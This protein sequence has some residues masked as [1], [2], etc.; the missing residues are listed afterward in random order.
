MIV[1]PDTWRDRYYADCRA[2]EPKVADDTISKRFRRAARELT[3][4]KQIGR[5]G[6]WNWIVQPEVRRGLNFE[7]YSVSLPESKSGP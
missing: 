7:V 6:E 5:T 3:E 1:P 2:R 4:S